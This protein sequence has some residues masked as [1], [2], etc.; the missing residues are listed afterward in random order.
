MKLTDVNNCEL[1]NSVYFKCRMYI[2]K[3][4]L[5]NVHSALKAL[6]IYCILCPAYYLKSYI[7][8]LKFRIPV[9]PSEKVELSELA[10]VKNSHHTSVISSSTV[11]CA[12]YRDGRSTNSTPVTD[13]SY[14]F[15]SMVYLCIQSW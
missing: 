12:W 3:C 7:Y 14:I 10:T 6:C 9:T 15:Y 13:Y 5:Y 8:H 1:Q 4:T 11:V 2:V